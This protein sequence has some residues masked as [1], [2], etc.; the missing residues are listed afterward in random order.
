MNAS[1]DFGYLPV[2]LGAAVLTYATRFAGLGLGKRQPPPIAR[3]FLSYVPIAAFAAIIAPDIA[4]G[5]SET[6]PRLV[7]AAIAAVA[8]YRF[9]KLWA[10]IAAGMAVYWLVRWLM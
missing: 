4:V 2:I 6:A 7:G 5:G 10:C 9:G 1:G 8:V 3:R